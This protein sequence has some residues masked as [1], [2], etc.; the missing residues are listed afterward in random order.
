[1]GT[2]GWN[3]AHWQGVFY[4]E[5]LK[6]RDWLAFYGERFDTLELNVTF[7]RQIN[8]D[9]F[10]KWRNTVP[11]G[12]LFSVKMSRFITHVK[13]LKVDKAPVERFLQGAAA[14]GDS[15]GVILIQ[16]PPSLKFDEE[17]IRHFLALLDGRFRYTI[18]ARHRKLR[19]R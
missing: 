4:P 6:P 2:S 8:D 19:K 15:L 9:V 12:F 1:M 3:Y 18:E 5:G 11:P 7:Y 10:R 16:L 14:L 17:R 13:R